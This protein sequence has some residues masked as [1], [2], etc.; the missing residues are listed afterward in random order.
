MLAFAGYLALTALALAVFHSA[1]AF[2]PST[3]DEVILLS[4]LARANTVGEF[5]ASPWMP[6]V[7]GFRPIPALTLV[8]AERWFGVE[9]FPNQLLN[10]TLHLAN[11]CL[12]LR[13]LSLVQPRREIAWLAAATFLVSRFTISPATW[14]ADRPSLLVGTA[15]ILAVDHRIR[16][17]RCQRSPNAMLLSLL[18]AMALLSKES[19]ATVALLAGLT[20]ARPRHDGG[21]RRGAVGGLVLVVAGYAIAR[22]AIFGRAAVSYYD[23]GGNLAGVFPYDRWSALPLGLRLLVPVDNT[24]KSLVSFALP[25]FGESGSLEWGVVL[26]SLPIALTTLVLVIAAGLHGDRRTQ[27]TALVIVVGNALVHAYLFHYR[28]Q[29][30]TQMGWALFVGAFDWKA[31]GRGWRALVLGAAPLLL[32]TSAIEVGVLLDLELANREQRTT[33]DELASVVEDYRE[34]V[35]PRVVARIVTR[36]GQR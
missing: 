35:D 28:C 27:A 36:Y 18:T 12:L 6:M 24:L 9:W 4:K 22:F 21:S 17:D 20:L 23:M 8:A 32:V 19:G 7:N 11:A 29:Y 26:Q 13:V 14:V 25:V 30:L 33:V 15:M 31:A 16:A 2:P 3:A 10:L 1:L 34:Y 5:L